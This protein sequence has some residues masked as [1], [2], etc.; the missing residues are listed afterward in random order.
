MENEVYFLSRMLGQYFVQDFSAKFFPVRLESETIH[1]R[2]GTKDSAGTLKYRDLPYT[3][4][5][6]QTF[7]LHK[8]WCRDWQTSHAAMGGF[9]KL[10]Y[11]DGVTVKPYHATE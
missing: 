8:E 5:Y 1:S 7:G 11:K 2:A 10:E 9:C 4:Y 3:R 6:V